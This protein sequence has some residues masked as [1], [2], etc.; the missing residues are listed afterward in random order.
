[1]KNFK[2]LKDL[3][4]GDKFI[5]S[6]GFGY[7]KTTVINNSPEEQKLFLKINVGTWLFPIF[8]KNVFEYNDWNLRNYKVMNSK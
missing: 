6:Y 3:V 2:E 5:I 8:I 7:Y 1:M 4:K